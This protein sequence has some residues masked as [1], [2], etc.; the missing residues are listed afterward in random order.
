[1]MAIVSDEGG[2]P[3]DS[4]IGY[5]VWGGGEIRTRIVIGEPEA[6]SRRDVVAGVEQVIGQD[7]PV[8]FAQPGEPVP[9]VPEAVQGPAA[10]LDSFDSPVPMANTAATY[11]VALTPLVTVLQRMF[12]AQ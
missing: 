9:F 7:I 1:M 2:Q 4:Y 5:P 12:S 8:R 3:Q 10:G 11:G 6:V